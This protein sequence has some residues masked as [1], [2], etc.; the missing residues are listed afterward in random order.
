M[1]VA[2][3][4]SITKISVDAVMNGPL[5]NRDIH[6]S[7]TSMHTLDAHPRCKKWMWTWLIA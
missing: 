2:H 4:M 5:D 6:L 1:I 7:L 3:F